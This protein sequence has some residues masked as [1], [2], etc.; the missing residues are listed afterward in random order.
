MITWKRDGK[1]VTDDINVAETLP[2]ADG[3]FQKRVVLTVPLEDRKN[4]VY[5]CEVTHSSGEPVVMIL[6]EDEIKRG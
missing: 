1:E 5:T 6:N 3:N 4:R 2:N